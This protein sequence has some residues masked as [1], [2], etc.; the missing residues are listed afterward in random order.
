MAI[1]GKLT[2]FAGKPR[3]CA[4][5]RFDRIINFMGRLAQLIRDLFSVK[6]S[7]TEALSLL[8]SSGPIASIPPKLGNSGGGL[9]RKMPSGRFLAIWGAIT[10]LIGYW[11]IAIS[12]RRA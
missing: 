12:R 2:Q 10:E 7:Q 1:S 9:L 6:C 4:E 8:L 3:Q 11:K 5:P